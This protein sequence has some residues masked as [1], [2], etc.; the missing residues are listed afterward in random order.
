MFSKNGSIYF[1]LI[2][3]LDQFFISGMIIS[4]SMLVSFCVSNYKSI[5]DEIYFSMEPS[6]DSFKSNLEQDII[7]VASIYG[8]NASGKSN[9]V[10][11]F[12]CFK[13]LIIDGQVTKDT[14][15]PFKFTTGRLPTTFRLSFE[16]DG[17]FTYMLT[18]LEGKV[19][20]EA[21]CKDS[22]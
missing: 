5:K 13:S 9:F 6:E 18:I 2:F 10:E 3:I 11:S 12:R 20:N 14:C 4:S 8:A 21:L 16:K 22:K 17:L 19:Q 1:C 15:V 7:K